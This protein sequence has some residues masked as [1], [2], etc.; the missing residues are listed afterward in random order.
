[1]NE[2]L[3]KI[4]KKRFRD[5]KIVKRNYPIPVHLTEQVKKELDRMLSMDIIKEEKTDY[6]NCL[7][8]VTKSTGI[9]VCLDGRFLNEQLEND[10]SSMEN[11]ESF[12]L[13]CSTGAKFLS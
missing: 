11:I 8:I 13:K 9:Y 12:F 5:S 10:P 1:M 3:K 2:F 6:I 7:V 4:A